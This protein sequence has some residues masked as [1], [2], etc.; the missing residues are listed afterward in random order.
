MTKRYVFIGP[1]KI[2]EPSR[3][4]ALYKDLKDAPHIYIDGGLLHKPHLKVPHLF[5]LGDGDSS[6]G[7]AL[8]IGHP[9]EKDQSDFTL[10]LQEWLK[11]EDPPPSE[12]HLLGLWGGRLDHSLALLGECFSFLESWPSHK[13]IYYREDGKIGGILFKGQYEL[14]FHGTFSLFALKSNQVTISGEAKYNGDFNLQPLSSLGLSNISK[15]S[16]SLCSQHPLLL[17]LND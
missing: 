14:N 5:S 6:D 8:D 2:P 9:S 16:V 1:M 10:A 13:I 4:R 7:L 15:G 3:I 12:L 17:C 11:K